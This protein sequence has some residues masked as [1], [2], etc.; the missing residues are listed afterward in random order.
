MD[1]KF[2]Y[3]QDAFSAAAAV[4]GLYSD[5]T[6]QEIDYTAELEAI[7]NQ[8]EQLNV[9]TTRILEEIEDEQMFKSVFNAS[10]KIFDLYNSVTGT[11]QKDG[12]RSK[13]YIP[14]VEAFIAQNVDGAENE[15]SA[16]SCMSELSNAI[17]GTGVT[18]NLLDA[19]ASRFE[20][21]TD[22][23]Q[24]VRFLTANS[25]YR[26]IQDIYFKGTV[27]YVFGMI[28]REVHRKVSKSDANYSGGEISADQ[29]RAVWSTLSSCK[30]KDDILNALS[31]LDSGLMEDIEAGLASTDISAALEKTISTLRG[32]DSYGSV[33]STSGKD[34]NERFHSA[35]VEAGKGAVLT[36]LQL[37]MT[38][39]PEGVAIRA[40]AAHLSDLWDYASG[41]RGEVQDHKIDPG[42]SEMWTWL[43]RAQESK[44]YHSDHQAALFRRAK[45]KLP[46]GYVLTGARLVRKGHEYDGY[47]HETPAYAPA[48]QI[49][50]RK[51]EVEE[52]GFKL[53]GDEILV[54]DGED[55]GVIGFGHYERVDSNMPNGNS[56]WTP[57]TEVER[58]ADIN[59]ELQKMAPVGFL[60]GVYLRRAEGKTYSQMALGIY[61]V[62]PFE[63]LL[64]ED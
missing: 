38:G 50:G 64:Q 20:R 12:S 57:R 61:S 30:S 17:Q 35:W 21:S 7:E 28:L 46:D 63:I 29:V 19:L 60:R 13:P 45:L 34:Y 37:Y 5:A 22:G 62:S 48:L 53:V 59:T 55:E 47:G 25:M 15:G 9:T 52:T 36:S 41:K 51:L 3:I 56:T 1:F 49:K 39:K 54:S 33:H 27:V 2:S 42:K 40:H 58:E 24:S 18:N 32:L 8:L 11:Q 23:G 14:D 4:Y 43:V 26:L 44:K 6:S 10:H 31:D 16:W